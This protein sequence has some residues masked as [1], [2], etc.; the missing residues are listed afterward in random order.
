MKKKLTGLLILLLAVAFFS[1]QSYA[2]ADINGTVLYHY[3]ANKPIPSV[4]LSLVDASGVVVGT[5]TTLLNGTY[6]FT[7]VPF[8]TYTLLATTNISSGGVTMGDAFLMF[9]NL[10]NLYTYTPIQAL[11]ADVDGDGTV[12]WDDYWTVVLGWFI[13]GY[14]FPAG[15]WT[16]QDVTFAHTG[17]KTNVPTMGGSSSGD[18]NGTFVP[19]TRDVVAI[20]ATYTEKQAGNDFSVEIYAKDILETSAMGMVIEYPASM[21]N[22][23]NVTSP[24]G[25]TNMAVENGQIRLN[26][27]SQSNSSVTL[28]PNTPVLVINASTNSTYDGSNIRFVINP[29]SNFSNLKGDQIDTRYSLPLITMQ[30]NSLIGNYPNPFNGSTNIGFTLPADAKVNISL[31]NQQGQLVKVI[32][33]AAM[34]AGTHNINFDSD[35]LQAGIYYYTLKTTGKVNLNET[36]QM[37]ITR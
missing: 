4:N 35:G 14:P 32:T 29:E 23:N 13:Q 17:A 34:D 2:Q 37:I 8:G 27:I 26:W 9:L 19:S 33:N 20:Q 5:A 15:P 7:N 22:I 1:A 16:F 21:V 6:S 36:K 28:D 10:C 24:L 30:G 25:E 18:V 12:T 3:K 31:F 11:A